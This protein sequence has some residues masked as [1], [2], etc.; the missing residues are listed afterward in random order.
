MPRN[1]IQI[2]RPLGRCPELGK[3]KYNK[4][5]VTISQNVLSYI[6]DGPIYSLI[7]KEIPKI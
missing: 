4:C 7:G 3:G 2:W 5:C 6:K 1:A